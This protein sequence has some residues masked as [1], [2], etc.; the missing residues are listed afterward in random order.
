MERVRAYGLYILLG[1][2]SAWLPDV[3]IHWLHPLTRLV[4]IIITILM[5]LVVALCW[6]TTSRRPQH[7]DHRIGLPLF[8]ILGIWFFGPL[9]VAI[10]MVPGG[11]NFLEL[12]QLQNFFLLWASF[13]L[14]TIMMSTY[15][16]SLGGVILA[17]FFLLAVVAKKV[18]R[19]SGTRSAVKSS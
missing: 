17:T 18:D 10:G 1:G 5:P 12:D 3:I 13:P 16:G 9:A 15:S 19:R 11:G 7:A 14:T 4:I 2:A 8:M 6:R